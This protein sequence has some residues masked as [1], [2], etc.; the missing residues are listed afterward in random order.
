MSIFL[1]LLQCNEAKRKRKGKKEEESKLSS[2]LI[3]Q[4]EGFHI[5]RMT[6]LV[7]IKIKEVANT[8]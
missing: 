5:R 7:S 6:V 1:V 2:Q 3:S 8:S 4:D